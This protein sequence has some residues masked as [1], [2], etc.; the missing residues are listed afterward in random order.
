[1]SLGSGSRLRS[2]ARNRDLRLLLGAG[3]VS[4][5][6]DWLLATGLAF[7]VYALTGSTLAS[8]AALFA[9]QLPQVVLGSVAGVFVDR[10]DGRRVIAVVNLLLSLILVPLFLVRDASQIWLV[11]VVV[12]ASS[13]LTPFSMAAQM[14]LLPSLVEP[15]E[16]VT[17]NAANAQVQNVA[18]LVGAAAGGLLITTGGLGWLAAVDIA[19]FLLAAVLVGLVRQRRDQ[20]RARGRQQFGRDWVE[21][22][23]VIRGSRALVVIVVFFAV[24]G[25]GEATMGTLFAPFVA[26]VVGGTGS[27]F[28]TIMAA[29]AVGG[30]AG[31]L[32]VTAFGHRFRPRM[33]FAWGAVAFGIGDLALF[34]YPLVSSQVWPAILII[35]VV[36]LPGAALFA[37]MLTLFQTETPDHARG[38]VFGALTTVQNL[39]MLATTFA[40]G[41]AAQPL[42]IVPVISVQGVVYVLV[43]I[44]VLAALRSRPAISPTTETDPVSDFNRDVLLLD[45]PANFTMLPSMALASNVRT[46]TV[47]DPLAMRALAH[48]LRQQLHALVAREG[49][50]T[51]ADAARQLGIS[52][53]LASHHLRQLAKYGFIEPAEA[54]DKKQ[55]PWRVTGTNLDL[56]PAEPEGR[57]T[58]DVLD[59]Y[60]VEKAARQLG[61]WQNR[62][63]T[64]DTAW[65][66]LAGVQDSILYLTPDELA[67]VRAAWTEIIAPLAAERPIGH[68]DRRPLDTVPVNLTLV[69][70]PVP[71][72]EHGG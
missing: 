49:S 53:A 52:H 69:V 15:H 8:A 34:L 14:T 61:E 44:G 32:L 20:M 4:Q 22:L 21:G 43:G 39:V 16:L 46:H 11:I 70:V 57:A 63:D 23:R 9:T 29:Q 35:V 50:L 12:A 41:A 60:A 51:A 38:R 10:W 48:P 7:Q 59:R 72:T 25:L 64:E 71:A 2:V 13:C 5:T 27:A 6:G 65:A 47:Q 28:G 30:I 68:A 1:M 17:A 54:T 40:A 58:V 67:R 31:G 45:N 56:K 62:R 3:L 37:G 36:G 55:H 19:T 33:L 24:S 42:G 18:R 66:D 26:D